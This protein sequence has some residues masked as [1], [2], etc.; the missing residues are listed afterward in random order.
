MD[1]EGSGRILR[2]LEQRF[3][4]REVDDAFRRAEIDAG[5]G[6][7]VQGHA[8]TVDQRNLAQFTDAAHITFTI[9]KR[10]LP[11]DDTNDCDQCGC[12]NSPDSPPRQK[13]VHSVCSGLRAGRLAS[14]DRRQAFEI[15]RDGLNAN[16]GAEVPGIRR[17]PVFEPFARLARESSLALLNGPGGR[18]QID[19]IIR[20][21]VPSPRRA[22]R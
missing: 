10:M 16:V 14:R 5:D 2:H 13:R 1:D 7:G 17:E 21:H 3:A 20:R 22:V 11:R 19:G 8:G 15:G 12:G 4:S 9:P 6:R 18:S